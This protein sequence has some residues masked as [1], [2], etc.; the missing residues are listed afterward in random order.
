MIIFLTT[1]DHSYTLQSLADGGFG[2]PVPDIEIDT[3]ER[4]MPQTEVAAATYVF[5]DLER[6]TP[7]ETRAA[8]C[9]YQALR[10][11]GLRV[12]NN[13]ARVKLRVEFLREMHRLGIN[14]FRAYRADDCPRPDRFPV[15]I[16]SEND[17]LKSG[18]DLIGDQR[19]LEAA[20]ARLQSDGMPLRGMLVIEFCASPYAEGIWHKWGTLRAAASFSL[21]HIAVDDNWLVKTGQW[22]MLAENIVADEYDAVLSNRFADATRRAFDIAGIEFGRADHGLHDGKPVFYEINTNPFVGH[23]VRDSKPLRAETQILVRTRF[24][25]ALEQIDCSERG[26]ISLPP[27]DDL[28]SYRLAGPGSAITRRP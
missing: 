9:L 15:F 1:S 26:R 12:L 22:D 28:E 18:S 14:P 16:R 4:V 7:A 10:Q 17:H 27:T 21:D 11:A 3:Y 5:T 20:L 6:L 23:Y 25:A 19:G 13:P 8:S 24:A 2:F